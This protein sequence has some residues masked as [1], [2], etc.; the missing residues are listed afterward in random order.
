M[1]GN[2]K[3]I[4]VA[5]VGNPN[6]G[7]TTL[8]NKLTGSRDSVA[9]Y[10]RVTLTKNEHDIHYRG[11]TL[12]IVDLPG[13]YSLTS[14]SPEERI[15]RDYIQ[16]MQPDIVLNVL[17]AGNLDRN[18]F[19]TTQLLEMGCPLV[20]AMNMIDE[21]RSKQI[22]F[23]LPALSFMLG[24]AVVETD[25]A[26]GEGIEAL[27]S[28][29]VDTA[30][31]KKKSRLVNLPYD[32]HLEQ[33]VACA[34]CR[35]AA[36][37]PDSMDEQQSRWLAIKLLEGDEDILSREND[38][39]AL[40]EAMEKDRQILA[41]QHSEEVDAMFA[42]ARY[43]FI[44]GMLAEARQMLP[45]PTG[46]KDLT[47]RLDAL[48]LHPLFG[49]PIFLVMMWVMFES[50]FSLG[51]IP[52]GWI[53]AGVGWLS[54]LL[55]V[56]IPA[57]MLHDLLIDGIIAGVGGTIIFLPNIVILFMFLAFFSETGYLTRAAF[58]MDRLM[59]I[60]GLHGKAFI[61][62]VIGFGCNVP[63]VMAARTIESDKARLITILVSPF[64]SCSAR[65]P[66]F[67]LFAGAF[68]SD[69]AGTMVFIMYMLSIVVAMVAAIF[70][71][72]FVVTG[73]SEPF[74]MEL[75]PYRMPTLKGVI[76]HMWEKAANFLQK[77][78]GVI[79]IGSILIWFLQAFPQNVEWDK[80]YDAQLMALEMQ[81]QTPYRDRQIVL[82][83]RERAQER[84]R[85][86]YLGQ[87]GTAV[88]P[89]FAPLGFTWKDT[90][91]ILTGFVAKEVVVA[92][93]A[94]LY[95]QDEADTEES[96]SLR[97]AISG[98]MSQV[99]AFAFMVF[100]LLYAPCLATI[101]AIR[102]E[103]GGWR[104]AGFSVVFSLTIAYSLAFVVTLLGAAMT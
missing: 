84:M 11:W 97:S 30:I 12:R 50:T 83:A 94:V 91:A 10:P 85:K 43:G 13:I 21:A 7:K 32:H 60:F 75:P 72:K 41:R 58:L 44:R 6:C 86:S 51:E 69:M 31:G 95:N 5:L 103:A 47:Q 93:Y 9:N 99:T 80:D 29:I 90:V 54:D 76:Y 52:M 3:I 8:S 104:W 77:V 92:S 22:S 101:A 65:L 19:L 82:L 98:S 79:L 36:L 63:A 64:M 89:V 16:N 59:H 57:G 25:A 42:A 100:A 4:T 102:R 37:H 1:S 15:G 17:D 38:H 18:L 68:F 62:L 55:S 28:A 40:I 56:L 48:F 74:V 33:A 23:D 73:V 20:F 14:Q 34:Q 49:L 78:A 81:V 70:L 87:I 26:R 71:G 35:I 88:S 39:S 67:I 2:N 27:L 66:V 45:D 61:P 46:H 53:D 24:G 96:A